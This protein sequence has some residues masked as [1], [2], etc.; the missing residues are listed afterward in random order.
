MWM[1]AV[2]SKTHDF[3]VAVT[4]WAKRTESAKNRTKVAKIEAVKRDRTRSTHASAV[5][6]QR[7]ERYP[8]RYVDHILQNHRGRDSVP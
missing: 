3:S 5:F 2:L 1:L 4:R 7:G 8:A 6:L